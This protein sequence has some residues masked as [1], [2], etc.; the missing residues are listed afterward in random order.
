MKKLVT[1]KILDVFFLK[2]VT[3]LLHIED[4]LYLSKVAKYSNTPNQTN[5]KIIE[6]F[7]RA[8]LVKKIK[9]GRQT[10]LKLTTKGIKIQ[11][12]LRNIKSIAL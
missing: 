4:G 12:I 9:N 10:K 7:E 5:Q 6:K 1:K 8:G 2:G 3:T 11:E